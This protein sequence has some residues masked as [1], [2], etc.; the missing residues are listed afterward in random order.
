[1]R[2]LCRPTA[3][4]DDGISCAGALVPCSRALL[5][6]GVDAVTTLRR[7]RHDSV[8]DFS[9]RVPRNSRFR[10][11]TTVVAAVGDDISWKPTSS[12]LSLFVTASMIFNIACA[13]WC[14][15]EYMGRPRLPPLEAFS[16][17]PIGAS[18]L[19]K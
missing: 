18:D 6:A 9:S 13:L 17:T 14:G 8:C 4:C 11:S 2:T 16:E 15:L 12:S 19:G 3:V 5:A 1:M 7:R 10:L